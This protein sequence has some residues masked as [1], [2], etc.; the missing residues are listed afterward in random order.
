MVDG[1]QVWAK[2]PTQAGS[3]GGGWFAQAITQAAHPVSL[4]G[5]DGAMDVMLVH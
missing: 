1:Y 2:Q 3:G 5:M 4:S